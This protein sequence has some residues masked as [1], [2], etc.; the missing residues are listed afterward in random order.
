MALTA[1]WG[2]VRAIF[3]R[4]IPAWSQALGR[5]PGHGHGEAAGADRMAAKCR[6]RGGMKRLCAPEP[7]GHCWLVAAARQ[8]R[9]SFSDSFFYFF[10]PFQ[11]QP[12]CLFNKFLDACCYHFHGNCQ[13]ISLPGLEKEQ[14][15]L[16]KVQQIKNISLKIKRGKCEYKKNKF[17]SILQSGQH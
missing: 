3:S 14:G 6:V 15:V 2:G 7:K 10:F 12:Q 11:G 9:L 13:V 1:G 17:V 16:A 8:R 4:V 5:P